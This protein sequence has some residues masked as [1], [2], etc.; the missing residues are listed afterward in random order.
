M[1]GVFSLTRFNLFLHYV[2]AIKHHQ[3]LLLL[4]L[5]PLLLSHFL[6]LS[7]PFSLLLVIPPSQLYPVVVALFISQD[8]SVTSTTTQQGDIAGAC[9]T[10]GGGLHPARLSVGQIPSV[11]SASRTLELE[12]ANELFEGPYE[13]NYLTIKSIGKGAFGEVKLAVARKASSQSVSV[14]FF[15]KDQVRVTSYCST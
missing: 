1:V 12:N 11:L 8:E 13:D 7:L 15:A 14:E 6:F 2:R 9:G 10:T 4:L 5:L 3:F